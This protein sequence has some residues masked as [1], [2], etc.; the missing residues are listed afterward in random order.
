MSYAKN[1]LSINEKVIYSTR[2]HW[3][4]FIESASLLTIGL[5][6]SYVGF[7]F[8]G[9]KFLI[10]FSR[11]RS[12][13]FVVTTKRVIIKVGVLQRKS[14][15]MPLNKIE[16]IEV[17]QSVMGRILN[18]GSINITGTGTAASRFDLINNPSMF[19]RKMQIASSGGGI[20]PTKNQGNYNTNT[21]RRRRRS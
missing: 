5:I 3:I 13:E 9:V 18:F 19:R 20:N 14:L 21:Q 4:I 8:S 10:E 1:N 2:L 15:S 16:S 7:H 17:D 12:S 6:V 11:L